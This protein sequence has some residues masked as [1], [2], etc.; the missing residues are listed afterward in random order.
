[1]KAVWKKITN[2]ISIVIT[3]AV[4]SMMIFTII[5]VTNFGRQSKSVFGY[6]LF[7]V[8]SDSMRATDFA[9]G[10]LIIVEKVDPTS[11]KPGDII[12]FIS[13]DSVNYGKT[14][15]HKIR[16]V[17]KDQ[18]GALSFVTYGTTSGVDDDTPVSESNVLGVYRMKVPK[19]GKFFAFIKTTPGYILFVLLPFLALILYYGLK[20]FWQFRKYMECEM[21]ELGKERERIEAE[22]QALLQLHSQKKE[23]EINEHQE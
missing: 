17:Q 8:T 10:D 11:L 23:E 22:K 4:I 21:A 20:G 12:S 9:A 15:S 3:I 13:E 1:M 18:Y 6:K 7:I 5:A 2:I 14:V 16:Q 19:V